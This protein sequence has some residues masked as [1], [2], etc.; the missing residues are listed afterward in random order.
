MIP[1]DFDYFLPD[2]WQEAVD[3]FHSLKAEGKNPLYYGGGTEIISMA[4]VGSIRPD[5][6]IDIIPCDFIVNGIVERKIIEK[7]YETFFF[8]LSEKGEEVAEK[9]TEIDDIITSKK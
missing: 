2:T 4:R 1:Y 5:A 3:I 6:V 7:P 9:L 8:T